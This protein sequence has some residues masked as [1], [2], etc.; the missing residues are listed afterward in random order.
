LSLWTLSNIPNQVEEK[1]IFP[2][3]A[4]LLKSGSQQVRIG[5]VNLFCDVFQ[6]ES[7]AP[8]VD[9]PEGALAQS[10]SRRKELYELI[11][12]KLLEVYNPPVRKLTSTYQCMLGELVMLGGV[13]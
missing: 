10:S 2:L 3:V 1:W 4:N 6:A 8:M 12:T 7:L 11:Y 13:V 9:G 5:G